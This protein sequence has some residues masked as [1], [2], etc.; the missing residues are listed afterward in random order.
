MENTER[1]EAQKEASRRNGEQSTGPST[2]AG[3]ARS[4][5]NA[6]KHGLYSTRVVLAN[7]NQDAFDS[8]YRT[9]FQEFQPVGQAELDMVQN[10]AVNRWKAIRMENMISAAMDTEMFIFGESFDKCFQPSDPA[11][12]HHDAAANIHRVTPGILDLYERS[13]ARY[14]RVYERSLR[15]LDRLQTRRLGKAPGR[16]V[17]FHPDPLPQ[18]AVSEEDPQNMRNEPENI[19]HI[20][21][22]YSEPE[23]FHRTCTVDPAHLAPV[24]GPQ[25]DN[26]PNPNS[27]FLTYRT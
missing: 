14:H 22:T 20:G 19:R 27:P 7:E 10:L 2:E 3:R 8:L 26:Q 5:Q 6:V 4:S 25:P 21:K 11:M 16:N 1:T 13:L 23:Q 9:Y 24:F 18:T 15:T 17:D 12:R